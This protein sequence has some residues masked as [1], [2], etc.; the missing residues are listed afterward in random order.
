MNRHL[1]QVIR[2]AW[3]AVL[4]WLLAVGCNEMQSSAKADLVTWTG[5]ASAAWDNG[6]NWN[7]GLKPTADGDVILPGSVPATGSVITLTNGELAKSLS[8]NGDYVLSDG[9]LTLTAGNSGQV[10]VSF[11]STATIASQLTGSAGLTKTGRGNLILTNTANNYTGTTTISEGSVLISDERVFGS[12]PSAIVVSGNTVRGNVGGNLSI[13]GG[14]T[15]ARALAITGYG[16]SGDAAALTSFGSNTF[17]G[18]IT[19]SANWA[20]LDASGVANT[21]SNTML[22][23]AY[24]T[25]TVSTGTITLAA[26]TTYFGGRS[27]WLVSS[28]IAGAGALAKNGA[29]TLTLT[30]SNTYSGITT[31]SAG[32]LRVSQNSALGVSTASSALTLSGGTLEIRSDAPD[33]NTRKVTAGSSTATV[34]VD[35]AVG[36]SELGQTVTFGAL[37]LGYGKVIT[38]AGR[39][40][41]NVKF[42][43][44][45]GG[46]LGGDLGFTNSSNGLLTFTGN[47]WGQ[48]NTSARTLTLTANGD[49]AITGS[50]TASG[51]SHNLTKAG[52]GTLTIQGTAST[53]LGITNIQYGTLAIADFGSINTAANTSVINMGTTTYYTAIDVIGS[54]AT[55][56][57]ATLSRTI[58]MVGTTGG[59]VLSADQTKNALSLTGNINNTGAGNK[60]LFLGGVST[61]D[62]TISGII[63]DNTSGSTTYTTSLTKVGGGTWVLT[64]ANTYTGNTTITQGVLKLQ[65]TTGSTDI[66]S[67][68][69]A[70]TFNA[71]V[72][73][74]A[75]GGTLEYVGYGD[76]IEKVGALTQ[77]AGA[78]TVMVTAGSSGTPVLEF[79]S[80]GTRGTSGGATVDFQ[81]GSGK[82]KF[83]TPSS[84]NGLMNL[85]GATYNGTDWAAFD[86]NGYVVAYSAYTPMPSVA[87]SL[88]SSGNYVLSSNA[89]ITGGTSL[90]TLKIIGSGS[91]PTLTL[92]GKLTFGLRGLLFDNSNG[93]ALI[94]GGSLG[95]S[96]SE[97]IIITNGTGLD[98]NVLTIESLIASGSTGFLVKSGTGTLVI[99]GAN[100]YT[101]N[102]YINEGTVRLSG[103]GT[104]GNISGVAGNVTYL[105]QAGTIDLNGVSAT[106]GA[107]QGAGT[108]TNT[109]TADAV[110][111]LGVKS[112]STGSGYF[113]GVIQD[114]ATNKTS[115]VMNSSGTESLTGLNTYTGSTTLAAGTAVVT[116]L[117][118]IGQA[119]SIGKGDG[120]TDDAT[121]AASLVFAGGTLQYTGA[122][123]TIYQTTQTPSVSIDRLF[124]LAGNGTI[125]SSGTYGSPYA[126]SAGSANNATLIFNNTAAVAFNGSGD[127]TLTLQGS[128][129]GD[130]EIRLQ[131]TDNP[132]TGTLSVTKDGTGVWLLGNTSNTY[133]GTTTIKRG[134]LRA[135]DGASLPTTSAL[136]F[137]PTSSSYYGI[138]ESTGTFT[139]SLGTG[140]G[141]VS[142][143]TTG[144]G[145][146]AAA[147]SKLKVAIGGTA[148]PTSLV[149]STGGFTS[150]SLM[151]SSTTALAEV[152]LVNNINLNGADSSVLRTIQ[153]DDNTYA[154][155]DFA[156]ISGNISGTGGITKLGSGTLF[157]T[158][159]N[160]YTGNTMINAGSVVVTSLGSSTGTGNSSVGAWGS[161][162]VAIGSGSTTGYLTYIGTGETSDRLIEMGGSSTG[163]ACLIASGTGAWVLSNVTGGSGT[164]ARILYL[165]GDSYANNELTGA[166]AIL[167]NGTGG[168]TVSITKDD[169]AT[170]ILSGQ[171]KYSGGTIV[172]IGML[173]IGASSVVT[174]GTL[175]SGPVGI[176]TFTLSNGTVFAAGAD[177]TLDNAI[178]L[179]SGT[180]QGVIGD[181]SMTW[182]GMITLMNG[183]SNTTL[184]NS[185]SAGSLTINGGVQYASTATNNKTF[186]IN[187]SGTTVINGN[188]TE[189]TTSYTI[190]LAYTGYG[191][192]T[193]GGTGN[194]YSGGTTLS[195]GTL[196]MGADNALPYG[197]GKGDLTINPV[198]GQT[199]TLDLNGHTLSLNGMTANSLGT[200]V[201]NNSSSTA[202]SLVFGNNT[203]GVTYVGSI[204]QTGGGA[205]S[206]TKTGSGTATLSQGP[207][208][209]TGTTTV[210]GGTLTISGAVTGTTGIS[211][212][213]NS[214]LY[215]SG[216]LTGSTI[217]SVIVD[218]GSTLSLYNGVG[219]PLS[220]LNTVS[221]GSGASGSTAILELNLGDTASDTLTIVSGGTLT[222]ANTVTFNLRD[223]DMSGNSQYALLALSSGAIGS[224]GSLDNY[225]VGNTPGGFLTPAGGWLSLSEDGSTLYFNTGSLITGS[226]YWGNTTGNGKWNTGSG[227][228]WYSDKAGTIGSSVNP[229]AGSDVVFIANTITGGSSITTTL[230][231]DF[232][233]NSLTFEA[234]STATNTP[235]SVTIEPGDDSY[236]LNFSPQASTAGITI[237]AGGPPSV[238]I[239]A[240]VKLG[241]N[242]TWTVADAASTLK[243]SGALTGTGNLITTGSGKVVLGAAADSAFGAGSVTVNG[244]SLELN[245]ATALG[246]SPLGN[247]AT[248]TVGSGGTFYYANNTATSSTTGVANP[249]V[250]NGGTLT[251]A[252][253]L[254]TTGGAADHYYLGALTLTA[255]SFISLADYGISTS[256]TAHNLYYYGTIS[257]DHKITVS[258]YA[259][260]SAG[261]II[262][263]GFIPTASN[264]GWTGGLQLDGG[265]AYVRNANALGSGTIQ[266]SL[267][268]L[269]FDYGYNDE[270]Y[271]LSNPLTIDGSS[272]SA[273]LEYNVNNKSTTPVNFTVNQTGKITLGGSGAT[274]YLRLNEYD[275]G[276][277]IAISGGI[278]LKANATIHT[279][280]AVTAYTCPTIVISGSGI[281]ESGGSYSLTLNGDT[282]WGSNNY[283]NIQIDVASSYTGGTTLANGRLILN[284]LKAIGETGDLTLNGGYLRL[285][286]D[287]SGSNA[288]SRNLFVGGT[289]TIEGDNFEITGTTTNVGGNRTLNNNLDAGKTLTI[290][291]D[292]KLSDTDTSR[293]FTIGGSGATLVDGAITDGGAA[294][295][296]FVYTG[297]GTLT[298]TAANTYTGS[299]TVNGTSGTMVVATTSNLSSNALTVNAGTL[300]LY[301]AG[302]SVSEL[303]MGG[304]AAGTTSVIDLEHNVLTLAGNV[305]YNSSTSGALGATIQNGTLA[306]GDTTRTFTVNDS[307][308]VATTDA[309]MVL[310]ATLTGTGGLTKAGTGT[311][312][313]TGMNTFTGTIN[314]SAGTLQYNTITNSDSTA[315]CSLG[316]GSNAITL[317]GGALSFAGSTSQSTNRTITFTANSTLDASGVNEATIDYTGAINAGA[318][319]LYLTGTG[320]GTISGVVTQTGTSADVYVNSGTWHLTNA[321]NYFSDN[322]Y[323]VGSTTVLTLDTAGVMNAPQGNVDVRTGGTLKLNANDTIT[324]T[325]DA[326]I[327]GNGAAGEAY[328]DLNGYNASVVTLYLGNAYADAG[329]TGVVSGGGTLTVTSTLGLYRGTISSDLAGAGAIT[330]DGSGTVVLSGD[331]NGLTGTSA[332]NISGGNLI[333]D[334]TVSNAIKLRQEKGIAMNGGSL[335]IVGNA[336]KA[337]T[338]NVAGMSLA[339]GW[340]TITIQPGTGQTAT[341]N[342]GAI[343]RTTG[344]IR[345][346]LPSLSSGGVTTTSTTTNGLL[347]GWATVKDNTGATNFATVD[348]LGNI[349]A[350]TTTAKDDIT[351]WLA[352]D[353]VTDATH[354]TGTLTTSTTVNSIRFNSA[355]ASTVSIAEGS[356]LTIG[357]GGILA[358]NAIGGTVTF[359]G[360]TLA[361]GT[362][363]ELFI[364]NDSATQSVVVT[365]AIGGTTGITKSGVGT[366]YLNGTNSSVGTLNIWG[367][368]VVAQNGNAIGDYSS[369]TLADD[370]DVSLTFQ[371]D[372]AIGSLSGGSSNWATLVDAG[373]H[374]LTINQTA[375]ANFAGNL[376]GTGTLIKNGG[377]FNLNLT[378]AN[379]FS[380]AVIVNGGVLQ[381]SGNGRLVSASSFTVNKNGALLLDNNGSTRSGDRIGNTVPV[382]LNSADGLFWST[383]TTPSSIPYGLWIRTDQA[384]DTSETVGDLV[385]NSGA[386]YVTLEATYASSSCITRINAANFLRNNHATVDVRGVNLG[387][388]SG[389]RT[390]LTITTAANQTAFM[391]ANLVGGGG[392]TS[393]N[394]S[395][396]PWAIGETMSTSAT[397]KNMG[398]TLVTYVASQGFVPLDLTTGYAAY[399]AADDT[400]NVRASLTASLTGLSGKTVNSL[401]IH[402]NQTTT[403]NT[404]SVTGSGS[405]QTL[406]NTS[407]AFL[408]TL[409]TGAT[410]NTAYNTVLGGFNGGIQIGTDEYIFHVVNPT[411]DATTPT[412]T[413]TVDSSLTTTDASLVKS[414]RGTLVL[415]Q[416]NDY[417]GGTFVNEGLVQ[418]ASLANIGSGDVT[419]NGGGIV[420]TGTDAFTRAITIGSAGG[421]I[422]S[423]VDISLAQTLT[424]TGGLTKGGAGTLTLTS[425]A[426]HNM[427]GALTLG[428][429]NTATTAGSIVFNSN[430][431]FGGLVV[432]LANTS[433]TATPFNIPDGKTLTITGNVTIGSSAE[434]VTQTWFTATG[435]TLNVINMGT[436]GYFTV[437][438]TTTGT[439]KGNKAT[440]DFSG[441]N[442]LNI[443]LNTS[444]GTVRVNPA[445]GNALASAYS[446]LILAETTN[447]TAANLNIGDN[448][449][450]TAGTNQVN[451][452]K[453][454]SGVQTIYVNNVNI[455]T[456]GR[457]FGAIT[458][459]GDTGSLILRAADG[460]GRAAFN[461]GA[462]T[463]S[464]AADCGSNSNT[465]DVTNHDA[466]LYLGAVSISTQN[467]RGGDMSSVFS[468]NRGTLD[469]TSLTMSTRST[470]GYSDAIMNLGGGTVRIGSGS[471][472]AVTLATNTGTGKVTATMELTGGNV[473]ILGDVVRGDSTST[474]ETTGTI[475]LDGANLDMSGFSIGSGSNTIVFNAMSGTL[476]NLGELNGGGT[477]SKTGDGT[478]ILAGTN[479]YTGTTEVSAGTLHVST[480][481]KSGNNLTVNGG[482]AEFANSQ[483]L[484][485]LNGTGG[486]VNV[487]VGT[488]LTVSSGSYDGAIAGSGTLTKGGTASDTLILNGTNTVGSTT[489]SAGT[490]EVDGSLSSTAVTAA[491]GTT[492][493]GSGTVS[494]TVSLAGSNTIAGTGTNGLTVGTLNVSGNANSLQGIVTVNNAV[495]LDNGTLAIVSGGSLT[496]LSVSLSNSSTLD[497]AGSLYAGTVGNYTGLITVDGGGSSMI[498]NGAVYGNVTLQNGGVIA[499]TLTL[500]G[501]LSVTSG[502]NTGGG[503]TTVEN[504]VAVATGTYSISGTGTT[505]IANAGVT[506]N[507]G[508][509]LAMSDASVLTVTAAPVTVGSDSNGAL[510]LGTGATLTST[511]GVTVGSYGALTIASGALVGTTGTGGVATDVLLS[512][513]QITNNGAINGDLTVDAG[514]QWTGTGTVEDVYVT[515]GTFTLGSGTTLNA[516][517]VTLSGGTINLNG[518]TAQ[519]TSFKVE[520][521]TTFT[522]GVGGH[523]IDTGN[524]V[525]LAGTSTVDQ[526]AYVQAY[527]VKALTGSLTTVVGGGTADSPADSIDILAGGDGLEMTGA[528]ITL[529][530][531]NTRAGTLAFHDGTGSTNSHS[532][533][534]LVYAGESIIQSSGTGYT[535][536]GTLD[537]GGDGV[538][539]AM[540]LDAGAS[541]TL[542]N[543]NI[544]NGN[545]SV[546]SKDNTSKLLF[547]GHNTVE[548]AATILSGKL[549]LARNESNP[550]LSFSETSNGLTIGEN[551]TLVVGEN[552]SG[553]GTVTV[554]GNM[555]VAGDLTF[556]VGG[557]GV[558]DLLVV[559]DM[560]TLNNATISVNLTSDLTASIYTLVEYTT[561]GGT[562]TLNPEVDWGTTSFNHTGYQL[563]YDSHSIYI[564]VVPE[565]STWAML[566]TAGMMGAGGYWWRR[567]RPSLA[568]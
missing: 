437:G 465:F 292:I 287:M 278:E 114:G 167:D 418:F 239:K 414:G 77:S 382:T 449:Q 557:S 188:I 464:T 266:A 235:S 17:T 405:G 202:A 445:N 368:D 541:L 485:A 551:A 515:G 361:S 268:R 229:G 248:V 505:L 563:G 126:G 113:T 360:G 224:L 16:V 297:T 523:L 506:V 459:N 369:V 125:D 494:G 84:S 509:T 349:V 11:Q 536:I 388:S 55:T 245:N 401:V 236:R 300:Q 489:I 165:R 19:T 362:G 537:L 438:G 116:T 31:I 244:G 482:T 526:D 134:T 460:T 357:S 378:A 270:T 431:T 346:E 443:T 156:T 217:R 246:S 76:S 510:A 299:T 550:V 383:G 179:I 286:V 327:I 519:V 420:Y 323:V 303:T 413:V 182:N 264:T 439:N 499:S 377:G 124:T 162:K 97:M 367:G 434:A 74:Q 293:T 294:A 107:L 395:I 391:T 18:D 468:F 315:S 123:G 218:G 513:G 117:A 472:T 40:G 374:T 92:G 262:G 481:L 497:I 174:D 29:G 403:N 67:S 529:N 318:Y 141:Q 5:D 63:S 376:T 326:V 253:T 371:T 409:N 187:G 467:V 36:G 160:S 440:A 14:I 216:S 429:T 66:L 233:I 101:G 62:N 458:F 158:G 518:Q 204:T 282:A 419:L 281:T 534:I 86:S 568:R 546:S 81:P 269:Y 44:V 309:E 197:S 186:V 8:I 13:S 271:T 143:S 206:I 111:S 441:L 207:Y 106:I 122:N 90:N 71:S 191:S 446:T 542:K 211:V 363:A 39:N 273:I 196:I 102:T 110:L 477:L 131:L 538:T 250:L 54:P 304:G 545:L 168:G 553:R 354:Y 173:G 46:S 433:S 57:N 310:S 525:E 91:T 119:S 562:F 508:G 283:Q 307:T 201:I 73:N 48:T 43:S 450:Y 260:T 457:D 544:V 474:G 516:D 137:S 311:L 289:A 194:S 108:I 500:H 436:N 408:F 390:N 428:T 492:L 103:S 521:G 24:G 565:P 89:S 301:N 338:Q 133:S 340:N 335:T 359:A 128:S 554:D 274:P 560:L 243:I 38:I 50:V 23:S 72:F 334:Y 190:A 109:G 163:A 416:A 402:N 473:T 471:G 396:I 381:L 1:N 87:A 129:T 272:G 406:I 348:E 351:T 532:A 567:R 316:M 375:V 138:L 242:Q 329:Y 215:L 478:L 30:G 501:T 93:S 407:G 392:T 161:N 226:I 115:V 15:V 147:D 49:I 263:G 317:S 25:T 421:A 296:N 517:S 522:T 132:N 325:T 145:G 285:G 290:T 130:N 531:N 277:I 370:H 279:S 276:S 7:G 185:I 302:Q 345:F 400:D 47:M 45:T 121:N 205:V 314:V 426:D 234:S 70:V 451:Q 144:G 99:A 288:F 180:T 411:S 192:L 520:A 393:T 265:T 219:T 223:V 95:D 372:E 140:S 558:A 456:G 332:P 100:T 305:T 380:G 157:L 394:A 556:F 422:D 208:N 328:F 212:T 65:D 475:N 34:F 231:Q 2:F 3:N 530:S 480:S 104:L 504:T 195:S 466:D 51:A 112:T 181:Y 267:G 221:L 75:A 548:G 331:N 470:A 177:R 41:Y 564:A 78:A 259:T 559:N 350:A 154:G 462:G 452:L 22:T 53:Y 366:L 153:V 512:G 386:N 356:T 313:L 511:M 355:A 59:V 82:I 257:G 373:S 64:G 189:A 142:W 514:G 280:S 222:I 486:T 69:G 178:T 543:L 258:S 442:T 528:T 26:S 306:M 495:T 444:S 385:F 155:T 547:S 33:F 566:L 479:T 365:S 149:W 241:A 312:A 94:T 183:S 203:G 9:D 228:N 353:N 210:N 337:T 342:V 535:Y 61:L 358:T 251:L 484:G 320:E 247:L 333:L 344:V 533:A 330:K 527:H 502:S 341:L 435:G 524:T 503:T 322:V 209:Y 398:N 32:F 412:L 151:L 172:T 42:S 336:S 79:A 417:N 56:A 555:S 463:A 118:N 476:S 20:G 96:T 146:F 324:S 432:Q 384:A 120:T 425:T 347:G 52:T 83:T 28:I 455:G 58:N 261:N 487:V 105:R 308:A 319:Y 397:V 159:A 35:R 552:G 37:T 343:T 176:G 389:Q 364:I 85:R 490:L 424:G 4:A 148:S 98:S 539:Q 127:R 447:I 491:S 60:T 461:L 540:Y 295:G 549:T 232:K 423:T 225:K 227:S 198:A 213:G 230:G 275:T 240:D 214:S 399:D 256:S 252:G 404:I 448:S 430:A 164:G 410:A 21:S 220:N 170:W 88:T 284:H 379:S 291:G 254:T 10:S 427:G 200:V 139:R 298:L 6:G 454:G 483:V 171:N 68:T 387:A 80:I 415:T 321:S 135:I 237:A 184:T 169:Y 27:D 453:L 199:A 249:I 469:M 238:E 136:L 496:A 488:T 352:G 498:G 166:T 507:G 255:N 12:D 193:L 175:V 150:G 561:P 339:K 152:E 493:Q